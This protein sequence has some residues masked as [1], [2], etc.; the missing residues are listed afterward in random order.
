MMNLKQLEQGNELSK[1]IKITE[2]GLYKLKEIQSKRDGKHKL[3]DFDD[4][5]Y[6]LVIGE[7]KDGS[8]SAI[9]SRYMGNTEL[10]DVIIETLEDQLTRYR[11]QFESL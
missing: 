6:N 10:V 2:D 3:N 9:L 5:Q 7:Y 8:S 4:G 1:I 11:T